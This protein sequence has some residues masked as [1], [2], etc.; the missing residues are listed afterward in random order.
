MLYEHLDIVIGII[1]DGIFV[2]SMYLLKLIDLPLGLEEDVQDRNESCERKHIEPRETKVIPEP[3]GQSEGCLL[4]HPS[5]M[6]HSQRVDPEVH[7][8]IYSII[9]NLSEVGY[10]TKED[11]NAKLLLYSKKICS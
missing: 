5:K 1:D 11:L 6:M 4:Q 7:Y 10:T 8:R 2:K 3:L 9:C